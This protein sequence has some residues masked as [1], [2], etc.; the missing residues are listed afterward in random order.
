MKILISN[1]AQKD[2]EEIF[3]YISYDSVIYANETL[4]KIYVRIYELN[5]N[6]YLGK[7]VLEIK[8]MQLREL[9]YK[10]YRIVYDV[11]EDSNTVYIHFVIHGKRNFKSY[12]KSYIK[13][14][15]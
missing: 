12:Y 2:L 8:F 9:I 10:S 15:F 5:K 14:N 7:V 3:E 13:N 4:E 6:P 11:S 1:E